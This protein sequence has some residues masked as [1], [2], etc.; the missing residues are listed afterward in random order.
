VAVK[1]AIGIDGPICVT[2][3]A[4]QLTSLHARGAEPITNNAAR[5]RADPGAI[6]I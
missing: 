1:Q 6:F 4:R 2:C 3:L 5:Q